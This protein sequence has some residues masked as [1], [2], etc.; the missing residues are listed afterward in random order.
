MWTLMHRFGF[1]DLCCKKKPYF[2]KVDM[3]S[4]KKT[5]DIVKKYTKYGKVHRKMRS[6]NSFSSNF[7]GA[8]AQVPELKFQRSQA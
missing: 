4:R 8:P 5:D 7:L 6:P 3:F 1:F 2:Q